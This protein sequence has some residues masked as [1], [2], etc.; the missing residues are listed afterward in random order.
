MVTLTDNRKK[1]VDI[2][3]WDA[4]A[5]L[6]IVSVAGTELCGSDDTTRP[7]LYLS[8]LLST[9]RYCWETNGWQP[10]CP[11]HV[12]NAT[13]SA[14]KFSRFQWYRGNCL[15]ATNNTMDIAGLNKDDFNGKI[16]RITSGKWA[17]QTR[18]ILDTGEPVIY[19]KWVA[20]SATAFLI[21]DSLKKWKVNQFIWR[22]V[23]IIS[24]TWVT[25]VRK[26]LYNDATTLYFYDSN[27]QQLEVWNNNPFSALAPYAA[28]VGNVT[29]TASHYVIEKS[30][31]TLDS[32]WDIN[33]DATSSFVIEW[34]GFFNL[35]WLA[36][37]PFSQFMFYDALSDTYTYKT[38]PLSLLTAA[39]WTDYVLEKLWDYKDYLWNRYVSNLPVVSAT[40]KTVTIASLWWTNN[41]WK[42]YNIKVVS[43]TGI[44]QERRI[45]AH[46]NTLITIV[47]SWDI[48][49]DNTSVI[50]IQADYETMWMAGN[51]FSILGKYDYEKDSWSPSNF[52]DY[53]TARNGAIQY[54][55]QE[56][57]WITSI[58]YLATW[59]TGLTAIPVAKGTLYSIWDVL[60]IDAKWGKAIV[61]TISTGW[62]VETVSLINAGTAGYT[63]GT[64]TTTGWTGSWCTLNVYS[65]WKT[66]KVVTPSNVNLAVWDEI[67]ISGS[68]VAWY[69]GVKNVFA[70]ETLNSFDI[71]VPD[72]TVNYAFTS[73]QSATVLV[74]STK[75]WTINEHAGKL[76][77]HMIAWFNGAVLW[78]K[79]LSNTVNT[80]TFDT[81]TTAAV[82][83]LGRYFIADIKPFGKA[84][85]FLMYN[86]SEEGFATGGSTTTLID[87]TKNREPDCWAWNRMRI[88]SGTGSVSEITIISNGV[89]TLTYT[90]QT[91][92]PDTTTEYQIMDTYGTVT[93]GAATT[94]LQ[95]TT[96]KWKV[97]QFTGQK[98]R[99]TSGTGQNIE[100]IIVTNT[101]NTLVWATGTAPAVGTTYAILDSVTSGIPG[102]WTAT[103]LVWD[104]RNNNG[105]YM[106]AFR[107]G[108]TN[109]ID[110]YDIPKEKFDIAY[111]NGYGQTEL[112]ST[113]TQ[114]C[115]D[116]KNRIYINPNGTQR[117]LYYDIAQNKIMPFTY[118]PD[119]QGTAIIGNRMEI[120][121]GENW[122]QFL[123]LNRQ[124]TINFYRILL[125]TY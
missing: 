114:Y 30:T 85:Q 33:P 109:I 71:L 1:V 64:K 117:I 108:N 55:W 29:W 2:D 41:Q 58:T 105:R 84:K 26:I 68:S 19:D 107:G 14:L 53:W 25:Q 78:R 111:F 77:C 18:N 82:N 122:E 74:D 115:F 97:N 49:L 70:I 110:R 22:Q 39:L 89:N 44:W 61:E 67:T 52:F 65:V 31:I 4:M 100:Q 51:T 8:Y 99:F 87:T 118:F 34:G 90:T 6:P 13:R 28:P 56:S 9:Y 88:T 83:G 5:D 47:R 123:Y 116:G 124:S 113:G 60:T 48:P 36:T 75:N 46:T 69:N 96:K 37:T 45:V 66:G 15:G 102:R 80:L 72:A 32:N 17:G 98:V 7:D 59:I 38:S 73:T 12:T 57:F 86:Q 63:T 103:E 35:G 81:I 10:L 42:N 23:R 101:V 92:T 54:G 106:Y 40:G 27:Y 50:D 95:D 11:N 119:T 104:Y 20:T 112:F 3:M 94:G 93:G 16:I 76:V 91:F 79:I 121:S 120:I 21:T 125:P 62:L 24:N 43:G